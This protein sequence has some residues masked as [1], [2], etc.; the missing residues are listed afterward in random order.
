MQQLNGSI[1]AKSNL[2]SKIKNVNGVSMTNA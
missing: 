2:S 1:I